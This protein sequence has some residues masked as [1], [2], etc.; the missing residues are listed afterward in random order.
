MRRALAAALLI[1]CGGGSTGTPVAPVTPVT[2][3]PVLTTIAVSLEPATIQVGQ[4]ATASAQGFD[5]NGAPFTI[6]TPGWSSSPAGVATVSANG[7]VSGLAAGQAT[8]VATALGRQGLGSLAVVAVPAGGGSVADLRVN[9]F[10]A[11]VTKGQTLQ[12]LAVAKD[13][14]GNSLA[15]RQVAWTSSAPAVA[16]VSANGLVTALALGTVIIEATTEGQV[17]G[18]ALTI[19]GEVDPSI[20]VAIASPVKNEVVG[21]SLKVYATAASDFP[22]ALVVASVGS[23]QVQLSPIRVGFLG[24][25]VAWVGKLDIS[26]LRFGQ[27]TVTVIATDD[28]DRR[29][30]GSVTFERDSRKG[31]AAG[32]PPSGNKQALPRVPVH[33]P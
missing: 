31:G 10:N 18:A 29:G 17:A 16:T 1:S 13:A 5:Q 26:L 33:I 22:I 14:A 24:I 21:D 2:P 20:V 6:G 30:L 11:V 7:T 4:T 9:P 27:Y 12:L 23:V 3:T 19:I 15:G 28:R 25:G 32:N 8:L